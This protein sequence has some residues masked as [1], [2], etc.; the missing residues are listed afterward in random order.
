MQELRQHVRLKE[1]L[2]VKFRLRNSILGASSF[3]EDIS[4]GGMR[5]SVFQN[6][7]PGILLDLSF[8][9]PEKAGSIATTGKIIW[10]KQIENC[11]YPF[12][13]GLKFVDIDSDDRCI[14][15]QYVR[16]TKK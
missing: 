16:N 10:H 2:S 12:A 8:A 14:I 13:V 1:R 5:L 4:E 9:V 15:S 7:E 3:S 11:R 6:F